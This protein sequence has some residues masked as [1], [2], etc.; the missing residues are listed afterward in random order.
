MR[1]WPSS[2]IDGATCHSTGLA[3]RNSTSPPSPVN[4]PEHEPY[5]YG[6]H[7]DRIAAKVDQMRQRWPSTS[8]VLPTAAIDPR[9]TMMTEKDDYDPSL[10]A[11]VQS[12]DN[13]LLKYPRPIDSDAPYQPSPN[14]C[15]LP[16]RHDRLDQQTHV[17]CTMNVILG[18]LNNKLSRFIDALS[19]STPYTIEMSSKFL[20][21]NPYIPALDEPRLPTK[22][23]RT[24]QRLIPAKPPFP[25]FHRNLTLNWTKANLRPP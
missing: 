8:T 15:Q 24:P 14:R 12:L 19:G 20:F 6:L 21:Q 11:T 4:L 7:L 2:K 5:D 1:R 9:P 16:S 3:L 13:F 23:V 10:L 22:T 18:E 25:H 17:L